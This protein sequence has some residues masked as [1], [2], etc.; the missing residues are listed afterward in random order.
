MR[1]DYGF[2]VDGNLEALPEM[3]RQPVGTPHM[4]RHGD[5]SFQWGWN[6][7]YWWVPS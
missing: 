3:V 5:A 1:S 2:T 6:G 4:G 7:P